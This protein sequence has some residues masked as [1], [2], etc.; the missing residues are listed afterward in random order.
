MKILF[1]LERFP[2]ITETFILNQITNLIELGHNIEIIARYR[3]KDKIIQSEVMKY[4]LIQKIHNWD[5]MIVIHRL[6]FSKK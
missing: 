4:N 3:S 2:A 1:F 5:R 6:M